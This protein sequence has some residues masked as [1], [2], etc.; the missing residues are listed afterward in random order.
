[1][2]VRSFYLFFSLIM[3]IIGQCKARVVQAEELVIFFDESLIK[4]CE[5]NTIKLW[6]GG[7]FG[8]LLNDKW[9][10]AEKY[11]NLLKLIDKKTDLRESIFN[12]NVDK[13]EK[14]SW[15]DEFEKFFSEQPNNITLKAAA[16][17]YIPKKTS[18]CLGVEINK[19]TKD[20]IPE[21]DNNENRKCLYLSV[22]TAFKA[23]QMHKKHKK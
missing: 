5:E 21:L 11:C 16:F 4:A 10:T 18:D 9:C 20:F 8:K 22:L 23:F 17:E 2:K 7:F 12:I 1:M 19:L 14:K 13:D 6:L 3:V 15:S